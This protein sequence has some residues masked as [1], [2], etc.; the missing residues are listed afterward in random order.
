MKPMKLS[1]KIF[2]GKKDE[3]EQQFNEFKDSHEVYF[4]QSQITSTNDE[5]AII[6]QYCLFV[7]Y[8]NL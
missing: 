3:V 5:G 1:L 8:G 7:F 6:L 2:S 4:S